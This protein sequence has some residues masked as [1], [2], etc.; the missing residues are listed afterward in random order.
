[1]LVPC[2]G[3]SASGKLFSFYP[4]SSG[5]S[6]LFCI[7]WYQCLEQTV[8]SQAPLLVFS[9]SHIRSLNILASC[10]P[11]PPE[12]VGRFADCVL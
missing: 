8:L 2:S 5:S 9:F 3:P 11:E 4:M 1:M 12:G 7:E 6:L 10:G